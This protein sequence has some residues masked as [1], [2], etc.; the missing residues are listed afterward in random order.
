M[1]SGN[2]SPDHK[3]DVQLTKELWTPDFKCFPKKYIEVLT[4]KECIRILLV[5]NINIITFCWPTETCPQFLLFSNHAWIIVN[6]FLWI[7]TLLNST[8][9]NIRI[10]LP[11]Y[12]VY[13]CNSIKYYLPLKK[14]GIV[15]FSAA[16]LFSCPP[17]TLLF[18]RKQNKLCNWLVAWNML[19]PKLS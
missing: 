14:L 5:N 4:P 16:Y 1:S 12:N 17:V 2:A 15:I 8:A 7:W 10:I 18:C 13:H 19:H 11:S 3:R 9:T 6:I